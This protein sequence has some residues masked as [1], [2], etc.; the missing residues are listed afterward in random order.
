MKQQSTRMQQLTI[1]ASAA[2]LVWSPFAGRAQ[3]AQESIERSL[4]AL[5]V[6]N[7]TCAAQSMTQAEELR[8][9]KAELEALKAKAEPAK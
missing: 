1:L 5:I 4:G 3:T 8:K 6:Q 7:A 9:V 2:F